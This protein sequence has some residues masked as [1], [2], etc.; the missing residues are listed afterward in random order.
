MWTARALMVSTSLQLRHCM[1]SAGLAH[2]LPGS[3]AVWA[4]IGSDSW[5]LAAVWYLVDL[6]GSVAGCVH[7][8]L[9]K[10]VWCC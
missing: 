2:A 10:L 5:T 9:G 4:V 6:C 7:T 1:P 8:C 3:A